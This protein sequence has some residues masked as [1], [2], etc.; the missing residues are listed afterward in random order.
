ME[1]YMK[2]SACI[3]TLYPQLSFTDRIAAA[4][5]DGLSAIEFWSFAGKK[6]P[7]IGKACAANDMPIAACCISTTDEEKSLR[8]GA[9][10][11]IDYYSPALF[12]ELCKESLEVAMQYGI[13]NLI[14]CPGADNPA[15]DTAHKDEYLTQ[16]LIYAAEIF[17]D[18]PVTLVVEPLNLTNHPGSYLTR[19]DHAAR[20]L[21]KVNSPKVKLLFDIYHQQMTEGNLTANILGML[22]H[23]GHFHMADVPGRHEIGSGEIN[24]NYLLHQ[25]ETAGYDGYFG[26]E[27]LPTIDTSAGLPKQFF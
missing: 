11:L 7:E 15:Q 6:L 19:S 4:K 1:I 10:G 14:V 25:I 16:S 8:F 18:T 3:E 21:Q 2:F 13:K 23:I 27:Y 26:L 22:P 12:A 17:K 24:W 20:I 9:L 5:K